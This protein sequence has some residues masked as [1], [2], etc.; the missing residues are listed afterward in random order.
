MAQSWL[1]RGAA[2]TERMRRQIRREGVTPN[3]HPLWIPPETGALTENHPDYTTALSIIKRRTRKAAR[4]KASRMGITKPNRPW[5]ENEILRLRK[6]YPDGTPEEIATAFPDRTLAAVAG[7]ARL[8]GIYRTKRAYKPTG[9]HLVDQ[10]L[11]RAAVMKWTLADLDEGG[12]CKSYFYNRMWRSHLDAR[13]L[14]RAVEA[15][16]GNIEAVWNSAATEKAN[17]IPTRLIPSIGSNAGQHSKCRYAA[18]WTE[19]D[20]AVARRLYPDYKAISKALGRT[21]EAVR[22]QC[23]SLG[24]T[25]KNHVWTAAEV[26]RLRRM[27]PTASYEELRAAFHNFSRV[28]I[29]SIASF[30]GFAR[31]R[32]PYKA[33]GFDIIDQIRDRAFELGYSLRDIDEI[34]GTKKYFA[35]QQWVKRERANYKAVVKAIEALGGKVSAQWND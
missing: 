6:V 16:G 29:A 31:A 26:S 32:R 17:P 15:L 34:S 24:L 19:D 10:V 33:T 12:G 27:Y 9:I 35:L 23:Q 8:R 11:Q 13:A 3:G 5:D 30:Y 14:T 18:L 21:Y 20:E 25:P 28:H 4:S 7:R 1:T 22:F 2:T